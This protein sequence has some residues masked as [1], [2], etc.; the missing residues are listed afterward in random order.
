M[1]KSNLLSD[2]RKIG[3]VG[4][5]NMAFAI[6]AG[7]VERGCI[8]AKDIFTSGPNLD[9]LTRW[10][11]MGVFVTKDNS[12]VVRKAD[13]VFICVKPNKL[14]VCAEQIKASTQSSEV[15]SLQKKLFVSVLAGVTLDSL[16]AVNRTP[17]QSFIAVSNLF[18]C[19]AF[20]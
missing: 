2:E 12:E 13:V 17:P 6:G 16:K 19:F 4:G 5:G 3:F 20:F 10:V 9:H 1:S 15:E 8:T 7:L 14:K 18:F 11:D